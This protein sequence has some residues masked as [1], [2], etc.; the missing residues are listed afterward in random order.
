[1]YELPT[2]IT[3]KDR[4]FN[5][6][7][8]GDFRMVLDCFSA[9]QDEEMSEDYRVLAC[10]LIF[11]NEFIDEENHQRVE[12]DSLEVLEDIRDYL[13]DLTKEMFKFMNCGQNESPGANQGVALVDWEQDSM[14]ICSAINKVVNQEI[15][16]LPYLHWWTFLGY[17]LAIDDKSVLATVVSI[18]DKIARHKKLEK[19][20]TEFRR[21]NPNYFVWRQ[22]T[23]QD[24]EA[25]NFIREMWNKGGDK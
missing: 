2:T 22:S 10:L 13:P 21:N 25:E 1:M 11:Y 3:V 4:Q 20:E 16:A 5:I 19:W 8:A 12:I 18:R 17:Y 23:V 7:N 14:M 6:T 24:R 9:L 15:R